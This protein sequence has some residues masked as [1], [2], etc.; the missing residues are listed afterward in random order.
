[1]PSTCQAC[2]WQWDCDG[3]QGQ[4]WFLSPVKSQFGVRGTSP[5]NRRHTYKLSLWD[6]LQGSAIGCYGREWQGARV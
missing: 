4:A 3:E 2:G 1:M 6:P 5:K